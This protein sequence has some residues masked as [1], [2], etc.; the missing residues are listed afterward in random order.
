MILTISVLRKFKFPTYFHNSGI[1]EIF[2]N[3][4]LGIIDERG[5]MFTVVTDNS[6][7]L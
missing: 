5:V 2:P 1:V 4:G 7:Q 3:A 6:G